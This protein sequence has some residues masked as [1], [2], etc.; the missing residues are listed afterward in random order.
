MGCRHQ[1]H[2]PPVIALADCNNFYVSCERVFRPSLEGRPVIVL[3][4]NDG[5]AVARSNEAKELG[6][7]MGA[8]YHRVKTLCERNGVVVLSSNYELYGD[9]SRRVVSVLAR[10]V[11]EMEIYSIDESFLNFDGIDDPLALSRK[12]RG[13]VGRWTGIPISIGLGS[14]KTLSKLAN[15]LAKKGGAGC[16]AI[17][18]TDQE[19]LAKVEVE[20][21]WGVGRRL[22]L[23]LRRI[24]VR[25][26]LDLATATSSVIRSVGGVTLERTHRELGG[27]R[28]LDME[29]V[30]QPKKNTCSSRSFGKPVTELEDLEEAVSNYAVKACGKVRGEASLATGIQ[31][32]L[33]TNRFREDLPQYANSRTLA[34]DEPTDDPIRVVINAKNLL[35]SIYREGFAYKKAGVILLDLVPRKRRQGLLFEE[36]GGESRCRFVRAMEEAVVTY[37]HDAGFLAAQGVK[38]SWSMKRESRTPRY[39]TS[40]KELPVAR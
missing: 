29:E 25:N 7:P 6:I 9:M 28:C 35:R 21:V 10:F 26:A 15:R 2:T 16:L 1:R 4:N 14:T 37:G 38:R 22:G 8:P 5:C 3:S 39:T 23:R 33:A 34:F 27:L 17:G 36:Y 32:F 30:S 31:V 24:G 40:W 11:S 13:T 20:E 18:P 12:I 19:A